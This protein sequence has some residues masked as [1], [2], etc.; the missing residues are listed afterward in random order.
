MSCQKLDGCLSHFC[1]AGRLGTFFLFVLGHC[2]GFGIC[3][4]QNSLDDQLHPGSSGVQA[5]FSAICQGSSATEEKGREKVYLGNSKAI[6]FF[7]GEIIP[8]VH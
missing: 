4:V 7:P 5:H 1:L 3:L 6:P 2:L 8:G